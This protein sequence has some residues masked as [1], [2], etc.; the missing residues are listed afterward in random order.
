MALPP[1]G[2]PGEVPR[3]CSELG[4]LLRC[5]DGG[6]KE[7]PRAG[8]SPAPGISKPCM[9]LGQSQRP[10]TQV[11]HTP[12]PFPAVT[13][14]FLGLSGR[15]RERAGLPGVVSQPRGWHHHSVTVLAPPIDPAI[16]LSSCPGTPLWALPPWGGLSRGT[17]VALV[18]HGAPVGA[19]STRGR[20]GEPKPWCCQADVTGDTAGPGAWPWLHVPGALSLTPR[21]RVVPWDVTQSRSLLHIA[22]HSSAGGSAEQAEE[23][24][25]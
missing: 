17:A 3:H 13:R 20:K 21:P 2:A 14:G 15:N 23:R 19:I 1:R 11:T 24:P 6:D 25:R 8:V 4:A 9:R 5:R 10:P 22:L 16:T 12:H 7:P 18:T